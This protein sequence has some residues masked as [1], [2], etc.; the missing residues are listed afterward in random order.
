MPFVERNQSGIRMFKDN[1]FESL[2][3]IEYLKKSGMS[4]KDIKEFMDCHFRQ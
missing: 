2:F 1:D 3:L 4:I